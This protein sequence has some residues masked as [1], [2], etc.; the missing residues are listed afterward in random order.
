[1]TTLTISNIPQDLYKK[2]EDIANLHER[3]VNNELI[4]CLES[5]LKEQELTTS[6]KLFNA[7]NAAVAKMEAPWV[8]SGTANAYRPVPA[9]EEAETNNRHFFLSE[10]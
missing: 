10:N 7:Q 8:D 9:W 6:D 1:M 4:C 3:S 2:L 5:A